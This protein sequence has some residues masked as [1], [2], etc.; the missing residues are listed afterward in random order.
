MGL[1]FTTGVEMLDRALDGGIQA[2]SL[3]ALAA[4]PASQSE[5]L[6]YE[7]TT[8][9]RTLYVTTERRS[10]AV[11]R[12][13]HDAAEPERVR[14]QELGGPEPLGDLLD[15][16]GALADGT[17][18]VV[19]PAAPLERDTDYRAALSELKSL[20]QKKGIVAVFHCVDGRA[21][22]TGRDATEYMADVIFDLSVDLHR[23]QLRTRLT[24]PKCRRGDAPCEALRLNFSRRVTVDNSRDIA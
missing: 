6:L 2:G 19:D 10:E 17:L 3:V 4:P 15:L 8:Q 9:Q 7:L 16:V 1:R 13:L 20:F 11:E 22:P 23:E 24:V 14:I 5:Q 21:V 12:A 18:V